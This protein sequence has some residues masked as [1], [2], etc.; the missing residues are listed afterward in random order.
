MGNVSAQSPG[1][2]PPRLSLD[3]MVERSA[4]SEDYSDKTPLLPLAKDPI[5]NLYMG[6]GG[7]WRI[8]DG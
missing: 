3:P 4:A 1:W 6:C 8:A 5:L 2:T 7:M